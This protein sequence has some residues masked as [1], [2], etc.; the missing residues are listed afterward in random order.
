MVCLSLRI[1]PVL[2]CSVQI[3]LSNGK[4]LWRSSL[5]FWIFI[6]Q[7][8][9]FMRPLYLLKCRFLKLFKKYFFCLVTYFPS[10]TKSF[11]SLPLLVAWCLKHSGCSMKS[12][13]MNNLPHFWGMWNKVKKG[14]CPVYR[15]RSQWWSQKL[16]PGA[17][18][19]VS[20][21]MRWTGS[22]NIIF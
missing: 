13:E 5:L 7:H 8:L 4:A 3:P 22:K 15:K 16:K 19:V 10:W 11:F 18:N 2:Q 9:F 6:T 14:I 20:Q 12:E 21:K 1:L 17:S